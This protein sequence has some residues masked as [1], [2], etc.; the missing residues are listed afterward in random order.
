MRRII[1][2]TY[3]T[4]DGVIANPHTWPSGRVS[5]EAAVAIQTELIQSCDALL[6]GRRTYESFSAA[7]P[8]RSGDP[9]SDR[10]N[11]MAKFVVSSTLET[12][13]WHNTSII[14][15][16]PI[17]HIKRLK[18][19]NGQNIVQY[20]FGQLS[21]ALMRRG[22][23]DEL[24]LWVH[25]FV[26]GRTGPEGLLYRDAPTTM[27]NFVGSRSLKNGDVILTYQAA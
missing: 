7:W 1:N 5:D 13:T 20:G 4:L 26:L 2:S 23:I 6:M 8:G 24:R 27:F 18:E 22:L 12:A 16:D 14:S 10:I 11:S 19:E 15:R 3:I 25:P 17:D 9:I 21:F